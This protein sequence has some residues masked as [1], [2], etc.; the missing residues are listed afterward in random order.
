MTSWHV[1]IARSGKWALVNSTLAALPSIVEVC[2]PRRTETVVRCGVKSERITSWLGPLTLARWA[3]SDPH[4]W[5]EINALDHVAAILGGWP[6]AVV[7]ESA[8]QVMLNTIQI[9]ESKGQDL[10]SPPCSAG[11]LVRFTHLAFYRLIARCVWVSDALVGVRVQ[12][13]GRDQVIPVP[14]AAVERRER[15]DANY[16]ELSPQFGRYRKQKSFYKASV[17]HKNDLL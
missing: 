11:D 2:A 15:V 14:W 4:V 5:H 9:I 13:L 17:N 7:T 1:V 3:T 10:G 8:V 12:I 16:G 6:P